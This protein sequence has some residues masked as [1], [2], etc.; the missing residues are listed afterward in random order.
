[1]RFVFSLLCMSGVCLSCLEGHASSLPN[2]GLEASA[3]TNNSSKQEEWALDFFRTSY[4]I[5]GDEKKILDLGSGDGSITVK[6]A[7]MFADQFPKTAVE[8]IGMDISQSMIEKAK[9]DYPKENYKNISFVEGSVEKIPYKDFDLI[10]SFSTLHFAMEQEKAIQELYN[11]LAPG[12][13]VLILVPSK[14]AK[15]MNPLAGALMTSSKW[16]TLFPKGYTPSRVYFALEEYEKMLQS[17]GFASVEVKLISREDIY[18]SKDK[19]IDSLVAVL[20]YVPSDIRREFAI[21]LA[22]LLNISQDSFGAIHY[23]HGSLQI[24]ARK[25]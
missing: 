11:S 19:F 20:N 22:N 4:T 3:Y 7:K 14:N 5:T 13:T 17:A 16:K 6:M 23:S 12:G 25:H 21:D 10:V 18:P 24:K 1:M 8:F 9:A 15:N 2:Q